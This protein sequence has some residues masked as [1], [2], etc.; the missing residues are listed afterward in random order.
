MGIKMDIVLEIA[1]MDQADE[2]YRVMQEV[3]ERM[4]DKSLYVCDDLEYIK[5]HIE[6]NGFGVVACN[7]NSKIVGSFMLRYP[8]ES[9]DNLGRDIGLQDCRLDEVVHM[10]S[11]VVLPEYRGRAL[12]LRMLKYAEKMIDRSRYK[13]FVATVSPDNKWSCDTFERNGYELVV[14]KEKFG[15]L[16]RRIYLKR[17]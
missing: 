8:G 7:E 11:V 13:Y 12:Q 1:K 3:Y 2:I 9:D 10:E 14:T 16:L 5:D 4:E 15:G 6:K 17:V